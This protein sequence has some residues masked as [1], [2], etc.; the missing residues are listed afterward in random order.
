[1]TPFS[2]TRA[3]DAA[4]AIVRGSATGAKY[5][6]GG[7]NLVDLMRGVSPATVSRILE[8]A[9]LSRDLAAIDEFQIGAR[10]LPSTLQPK[11]ISAPESLLDLG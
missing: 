1:M 8:R 2:Y 9:G 10:Q 3:A 5:L 6:G 4:D 11:S 7:T